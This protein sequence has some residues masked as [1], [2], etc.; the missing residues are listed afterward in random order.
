MEK[1]TMPPLIPPSE[2]NPQR[3]RKL[4]AV[5]EADRRLYQRLKEG[6]HEAFMEVFR[7][8]EV[9]L[10]G[11][12]LKLTRS[13]V[14][15]EDI[16]QDTFAAVW[17]YRERIDPSKNIKTYI[18]LIAKQMAWKQIHRQNRSDQFLQA[19]GLE[20]VSFSPSDDVLVA[21]E[22]ELL[23]ELVV[24]RMPART[25]QI[26]T[27]HV[28]ENLSHEEIALRVG[29]STASVST[30]LYRARQRLKEVLVVAALFFS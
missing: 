25:R 6:D 14:E 28:K 21:Q 8:W 12:L 13:E 5:T 16:S 26:Y 10:H 4:T 23:A 27:L 15:A 18:F 29:T 2:Q 19:G 3:E 17:T 11:F 22:M 20:P 7:R 24:S 30:H 9:P 1:S